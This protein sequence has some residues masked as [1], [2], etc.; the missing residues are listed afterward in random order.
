MDLGKFLRDRKK[1]VQGVVAQVNPFDGGKTYN[2]V[3]HNAPIKSR[4]APQRQQQQ[5]PVF[6]PQQTPQ[7]QQQQFKAPT[8]G[9]GNAFDNKIGGIDIQAPRISK[10]EPNKVDELIRNQQKPVAQQPQPP[11]RTGVGAARPVDVQTT[12]EYA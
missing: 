11:V 8:L 4:Q 7:Q 6:G 2:T 3:V 9:S 5:A 10:P 12:E 1:Q